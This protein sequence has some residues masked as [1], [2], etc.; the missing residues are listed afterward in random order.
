M[1][2]LSFKGTFK[3]LFVEH[4]TLL[5]NWGEKLVP[6]FPLISLNLRSVLDKEDLIEATSLY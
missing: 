1:Y 6:I 4:V 3:L 5:Q 2:T